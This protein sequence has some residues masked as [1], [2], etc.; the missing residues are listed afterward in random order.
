[1]A[2][3]GDHHHAAVMFEQSIAL[4]A[5]QAALGWQLRARTSLAKL[6]TRQG[7]GD[8]ALRSLAAA[9]RLFKEGLDTPDVKAAAALI[10]GAP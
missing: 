9:Y 2:A 7:D 1:M 10:G 8:A 5:S 3:T 6:R 4:A